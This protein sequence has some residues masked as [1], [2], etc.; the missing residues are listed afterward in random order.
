M[1]NYSRIVVI[2]MNRLIRITIII[3]LIMILTIFSEFSVVKA[4]NW[5]NKPENWW[6]PSNEIDPTPIVDR[7]SIVTTVI[8]NIGIAC[9]VIALM[10]IGIK[11]MTSSAEEK[12]I[13]KQSL[14]SYVLGVVMI[15]AITILPSIIYNLVKGLG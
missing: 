13:L 7:A 3:I 12:S 2:W 14:P 15:A 9:A 8:R 5:S 6:I 11:E 4:S 10:I 1:Y